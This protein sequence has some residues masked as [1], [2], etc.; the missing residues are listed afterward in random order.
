M[1][2][3][4]PWFREG[5]R[6]SP[7]D[8]ER[9]LYEQTKNPTHAW[10]ALEICSELMRG[11]AYGCDTL[12]HWLL[13]Y[14]D[15]STEGVRRLFYNPGDF[16]HAQMVARLADALGFRAT[17]HGVRTTALCNA[18]LGHPQHALARMV[19]NRKR[20]HPT[21]SIE[22]IAIDIE[23]RLDASAALFEQGKQ[24]GTIPA[25]ERPN[26]HEMR[27]SRNMIED[28]WREWHDVLEHG[29]GTLS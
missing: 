27:A 20:D 4:D 24:D 17:R 9:R 8:A 14:L 13:D 16:T 19:W 2:F 18:A 22:S 5:K 26:D 29:W 3:E 1:S 6:M 23:E 28:A 21:R 15:T 12:P 11:G 10:R 25:S 7:L